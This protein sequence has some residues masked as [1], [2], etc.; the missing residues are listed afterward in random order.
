[1]HEYYK[2]KCRLIR[3]AC[4]AQHPR[5]VSHS[6]QDWPPVAQPRWQENIVHNAYVSI[7][8]VHSTHTI[9]LR[10][11]R[12][13]SHALRETRG[14]GNTE[15]LKQKEGS[16]KQDK[17]THTHSPPRQSKQKEKEKS[18]KRKNK[19]KRN[20]RKT[21]RGNQNKTKHTKDNKPNK[22]ADKRNIPKKNKAVGQRNGV[23][24]LT[25]QQPTIARSR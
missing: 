10:K 7:Y 13:V 20:K 11:A 2:I 24:G 1:M 6:T 12:T 14:E 15:S 21:N 9:R 25:K 18:S 23:N 19:E 5:H 16:Y 8:T 3:R 17:H 4:Y 22:Q